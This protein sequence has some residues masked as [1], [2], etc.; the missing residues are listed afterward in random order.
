MN[1]I[2]R[3]VKQIIQNVKHTKKRNP[4]IVELSQ[5]TG[6][7]EKDLRGILRK[8]TDNHT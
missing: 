3:K 2:E 6:R 4:T 5:W 1:D 7:S 8:L